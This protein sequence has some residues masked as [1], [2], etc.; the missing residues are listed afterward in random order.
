MRGM[1]FIVFVILFFVGK[2]ILKGAGE[3]AKIASNAYDE[4]NNPKKQ[5]DTNFCSK[6]HKENSKE[7]SFCIYCGAKLHQFSNKTEKETLTSCVVIL[8]AYIAKA[9]GFVSQN[10]ANIISEILNNI[11]DNNMSLRNNLKNIY[12]NA[13]NTLDRDHSYYAQM[14]FIIA[15]KEM[16][17]LNQKLFFQSFIRWLVI[18]I[19]AEGKKNQIQANATEEIARYLNVSQ[20]YINMLYDE[21]D[22]MQKKEK[23]KSN[24]SNT[25]TL[26]ECY[27]ILKST[28]TS[29]N[30]EIKKS[31]R[32]LVK[33]Y[34]P[35][36]IQGKGLG[37]DFI[38]F[39]NQKFK[40]INNAY[41]IIRKH[42]GMK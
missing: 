42:K 33:Q 13:K 34:H 38:L 21:F 18:L 26:E 15:K 28:S 16:D 11:S 20:D 29:T 8:V 22:S 39:A 32:E 30:E 6:C 31:Y 4:V 25:M 17:T 9:D 2:L 23:S 1:I 10:E 7:S 41:E 14:M 27:I 19:Y 37:E 35:D 40:E 12:N 5:I 24:H 3:V 36:T